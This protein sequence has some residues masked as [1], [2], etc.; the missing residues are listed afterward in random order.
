MSTRV[1]YRRKHT[2]RTDSNMVRKFRTPGGK[3]SV[4]YLKK[5]VK[6]LRCSETGQVLP[7]VTHIT[8]AR[9]IS[10]PKRKRTVTRPYGGSLSGGAVKHRVMRAFFN[11][12]MRVIKQASQV[13]RKN[14]PTKSKRRQ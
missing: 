7:G 2:Y 4:Q 1:H 10:L 5:R 12:E 6:T 8:K 11:E 14:K 9:F 3:L 13:R